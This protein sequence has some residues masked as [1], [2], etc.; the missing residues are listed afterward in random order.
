M[1]ATYIAAPAGA[2]SATDRATRHAGILTDLRGAGA[3]EPFKW[4][5]PE[6]GKD[7]RQRLREVAVARR[8]AQE[9]RTDGLQKF[10]ADE[11]GN[12]PLSVK[13]CG[14]MLRATSGGAL[15]FGGAWVR[16]RRR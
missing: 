13:L 2:E 15:C 12:L 10:L 9:L 8:Q 11:L 7:A 3:P 5:R 16:R 6:N 4:L 14:H 1:E